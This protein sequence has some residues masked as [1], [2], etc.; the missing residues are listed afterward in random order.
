MVSVEAL[1]QKEVQQFIRERESA[2]T[3]DIALQQKELAGVSASVLA[4]QI[5]ARKKAKTKIPLYYQTKNIVYPPS[6]N[7]EQSSSQATALFKAHLV[8]SLFPDYTKIHLADLTGGFG[9]DSFFLSKD[10]HSLWHV[11]PNKELQQIAEHN[12]HQLGATTIQYCNAT[13]LDFLK[14]NTL[15]FN[16]FYIDPS[17][18]KETQR[19]HSLADCVPNVIDLQKTFFEQGE[20]LLLK[21]SPLLDIHV[22]LKTVSFVKA[23]F[24]VAVENEC[25]EVLYLC[26]RN[27]SGRPLIEAIDLTSD[28]GVK[29]SLLF[30][31]EQESETTAEFSEPLAYL[32]EP[33][34]AILKAGAFKSIANSFHLLKIQRNTHL[35]TSALLVK[36][37]PGRVFRIERLVRANVKELHAL[38]PDQKVN[39]I[40]RNYPITAEQ[41]KAKLKLKDG[42]EK[43]LL[44][45]STEH[46]KVIL[47]CSR[48][49]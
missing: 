32:Y 27:F 29:N 12:H 1:L 49:K 26:Q 36:D 8:K 5:M 35:Y 20:F 45:F 21:T 9:I 6:L 40:T 48:L 4:A 42:G 47:L 10:C 23:V 14:S 16:L 43:Y 28:G 11:E 25:K 34:A 7:L 30:T 41:L 24:I 39:V 18:R 38:I 22:V 46:K 31:Y 15:A 44:A 19:V 17:R 3:R 2:D 33:N 37:F 13:A